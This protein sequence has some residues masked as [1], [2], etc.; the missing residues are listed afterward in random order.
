[1]VPVMVVIWLVLGIIAII[2]GYKNIGWAASEIFSNAFNFKQVFAGFAGSC[3]MWGLKRGVFS[4]EAG[5]GSVPNVA[6]QSHV[7]HPIR[8]GLVQS[9]GVLIDTIVVCSITAF[10]VLTCLP[11]GK[12]G[13]NGIWDF[14]GRGS[15][16]A[17]G[18]VQDSM[19]DAFG[20]DWI[21]WVLA[22]FMFVFAF[23]SLIAYYSMSEA[24]LRF[25]KDDDKFVTGLRIFIVVIVFFA[26]IIPVGMVWDICDVFMA[27]MG[28]FNIIALFMLYKYVAALYKDYRKQKAAGVED[29]V[30]DVNKWDSEGLDTSGITVWT[31]H[32]RGDE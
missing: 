1:M 5:I 18:V 17:I 3:I 9:I 8:Q 2:I 28:I 29:P 32:T 31:G 14:E 30:F 25:I 21:L 11:G 22:I 16:M 23:S 10:M 7:N 4:N 13:W 27:I 26:C 19:A 6:S 12:D 24:N 15:G 20:G